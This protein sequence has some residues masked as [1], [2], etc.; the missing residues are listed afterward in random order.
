MQATATVKTERPKKKWLLTTVIVVVLLL[1]G[2]FVVSV[3][4]RIRDNRAALEAQTGDRVE[5][6]IG[7]LAA[8]AT[9]SGQVEAS[10]MSR[11]LSAT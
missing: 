9:A 5:A 1:V 10:Q 4:G 3:L 6:F 8:S 7:D 11:L 2:F